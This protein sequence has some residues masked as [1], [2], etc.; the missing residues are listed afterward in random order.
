MFNKGEYTGCLENI[1]EEKNSQ[2]HENSDAYTTSSV[3]MKRTMS[4]Q[5]EPDNFEPPC[6][7]LKL[8]IETKLEALLKKY[9]SQFVQDE[10]SIGTTSL[11]K[12]SI[13]T[14]NLEPQSHRSLIQLP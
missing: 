8:N 11:T 3:T 5:V 4:E 1:N 12:M 10:T 7:K 6:H 9:K 14:G 2:P 13:D